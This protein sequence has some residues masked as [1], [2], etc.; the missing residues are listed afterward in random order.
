MVEYSPAESGELNKKGYLVV[1]FWNNDIPGD[2][3]GVL[4][5]I[6]EALRGDSGTPSPYPSPVEGEGMPESTI[7]QTCWKG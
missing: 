6:A 3:E 5:S 4:K 2:L 1:R 7:C